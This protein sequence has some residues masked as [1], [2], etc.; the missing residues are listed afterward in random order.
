MIYG[1]SGVSILVMSSRHL[2]GDHCMCSTAVT[3]AFEA[4]R[5][6]TMSSTLHQIKLS[7]FLLNMTY[8]WIFT[9][10]TILRAYVS[11]T[12]NVMFLFQPSCSYTLKLSVENGQ[13]HAHTVYRVSPENINIDVSHFLL[14]SLWSESLKSGACELL[15][16]FIV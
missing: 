10:Q 15:G 8:N 11:H 9:F 7:F 2:G 6:S 1:S 14:F 5:T 4:Y 12:R 16:H 3:S 13:E